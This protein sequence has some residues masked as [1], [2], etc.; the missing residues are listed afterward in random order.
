MKRPWTPWEL[1]T[2]AKLYPDH[3]AKALSLVL[4]RAIS[5]IY[6]KAK[7]L[8]LAK[9]TE[10]YAGPNSGRTDG[11]RGRSA[12]FHKGHVPANK[13]QRRPGYAPGRMAETQFKSGQD[14]HNTQVIGSYRFD[15]SGTLQRKINNN[16]GSNSVR[17][18]GV[19]ELVWIEANGPVPPK[20]IVVFKPGMRTNA[21]EEI[22][23]DKVECISLA[24]N[25]RRNTLHRYPKEI[26]DVIR[27][28]A[29]LNR[30][31]NHVEKHQ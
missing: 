12:R 30:R 2:L 24:E 1:E 15:K 26:T 27:A 16:S 10:F 19:H 22:T 17:W 3:T 8:G 28:R 7:Q 9:S 25:M 21:L 20:H 23:L 11:K 29:V 14:P 6:G 4:D 13:G 31:I 5:A 18:R